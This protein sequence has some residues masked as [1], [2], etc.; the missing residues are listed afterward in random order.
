[1]IWLTDAGLGRSQYKTIPLQYILHTHSKP[2]FSHNRFGCWR[3]KTETLC[4]VEIVESQR[5]RC[6]VFVPLWGLSR[7]ES[8]PVTL[9]L[10]CWR[11][12]GQYLQVGR[13]KPSGSW[14]LEISGSGGDESVLACSAAT[15]EGD[16][17]VWAWAEHLRIQLGMRGFVHPLQI[18][19]L[20]LSSHLFV[21]NYVQNNQLVLFSLN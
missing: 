6:F 10:S 9:I 4:S 3:K 13:I 18:V 17:K 5:S 20:N 11:T 2:V 19:H 8:Q 1:M 14:P 12:S 15:C 16:A 21:C 7:T